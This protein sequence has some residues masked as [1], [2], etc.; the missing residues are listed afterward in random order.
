MSFLAFKKI[1]IFI[2]MF[3]CPVTCQA[4]NKR[5]R[6]ILTDRKSDTVLSNRTLMALGEYGAMV[7][8]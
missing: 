8:L 3:S 7:K 4:P 1:K 2:E 6:T 5:R